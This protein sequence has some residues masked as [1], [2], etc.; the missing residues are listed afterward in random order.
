MHLIKKYY[1]VSSS[2]YCNIYIRINQVQ[3]SNNFK[4][5]EAESL[6]LCLIYGFSIISA[7]N[8]RKRH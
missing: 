4:K 5:T 6:R 8:R 7:I 2:L 3:I 1:F